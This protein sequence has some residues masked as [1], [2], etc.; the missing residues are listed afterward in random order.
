MSV[1]GNPPSNTSNMWMR[2]VGFVQKLISR[3]GGWTGKIGGAIFDQAI[4]AGSNFILN[5]LLAR[6]MPPEHYGAFVVA[7]S[8]FLLPQNLYEAVIV[9]PLS[10][11]GAGKYSKRFRS[12]LGY[13]F[14]IHLLFSLVAAVILG[15]GAI[16]VYV[17]DSQLLGAAIGGAALTLPLVLTRWSSRRPFYILSKPHW[18]AI[19]GAIYLVLAVGGISILHYIDLANAPITLCLP[20][21][22]DNECI[23]LNRHNLLTPFGALVV[24]GFAGILASMMLAL[25][26]KPNFRPQEED[27]NLRMVLKDHYD[28]GR[29]SSSARVL[30][31]IPNNVYY[32]VLP[33]VLTL[34]E[35]GALRALNNLLQPVYMSLSATIAILLPS[36]VRLYE[37][38]GGRPA[39]RRRVNGVLILFTAGALAY[40][41]IV[42]VFGRQ[43]IHIIYDGKFDEFVTTP[44]LATMGLI[45]LA[46]GLRVVLDAAVRAMGGVKHSFMSKL[47]PTVFTLTIGM[48]LLVNLGIWGANLA[49]FLSGVLSLMTIYLVYQNRDLAQ[50]PQEKLAGND[51]KSN[52]LNDGDASEEAVAKEVL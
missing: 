31:W 45:P 15:I 42:M 17:T 8:W 43:I 16:F 26:L 49:T 12:Y 48:V 19:G 30:L 4:F 23:V 14:Y 39:L 37:G 10:I 24:M 9:E 13:T 21:G 38:K 11:Y 46:S 44:I 7:Y 22:L 51:D 35:S 6:W 41:M 34:S 50:P 36:F 52:D 40:F 5:V 29:W 3:Y 27:M 28:Y 25:L 20:A 33:V 18:S 32:L 1:Q 47:I 2:S